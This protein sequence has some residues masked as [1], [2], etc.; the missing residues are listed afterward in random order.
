MLHLIQPQTI[1]HLVAFVSTFYTKMLNNFTTCFII[2]IRMVDIMLELY[3]NI[4]EKRKKLGLTQTELAKKLGYADKSMIAKIEQ[5]KID[6]PQS[7]IIAFAKA[8]N[9]TP[10]ELMGYDGVNS[11]WGN[12]AANREYLKDKPELLEI[13]DQLVNRD[14]MVILFDKTKD[15]EPKD[16]E[17]VLMFVQTIRKQRGLDD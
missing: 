15:L 8:L 3:S 10:S 4:K 2:G 14:D 17:S 13:Y 5:G 12:D 16:V 1:Y 9:T 11:Q 7:K 6:L